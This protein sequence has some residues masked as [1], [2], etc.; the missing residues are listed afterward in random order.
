MDSQA[1]IIGYDDTKEE[2][3]GRETVENLEKGEDKE[4]AEEGIG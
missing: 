1:E 2:E 3:E 4:D